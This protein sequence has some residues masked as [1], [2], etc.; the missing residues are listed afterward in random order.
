M[1]KVI[2]FWT[3]CGIFCAL[4]MSCGRG[5]KSTKTVKVWRTE[6][7]DEQAGVLRRTVF[8]PPEYEGA[9]R[10]MQGAAVGSLIAEIQRMVEDRPDAV[11]RMSVLMNSI[12]CSPL[13]TNEDGSRSMEATLSIQGEK[14]LAE[15]LGC[16][17]IVFLERENAGGSGE[18]EKSPGNGTAKQNEQTRE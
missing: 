16:D 2:G 1:R 17:K 13:V 4:L 15:V 14:S 6:V 11:I 12:Q 18:K 7:V 5:K 9:E 3:I 10:K 8:F